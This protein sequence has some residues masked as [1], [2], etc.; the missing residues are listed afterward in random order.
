MKNIILASSS[1]RYGEEYLSYLLFSLQGHFK[2][3]S[4]VIFIPYACPGGISWDEY[5]QK[6]TAVFKKLDIKLIGLHTFAQPCEAIKKAQAI[7]TGGGNTF[8]L[9]DKLYKMGAMKVLREVITAGTPYLGTSA[10]SNI[11][12]VNIKNTNDMPIVFPPAFEALGLIPFNINPHYLD[13]IPHLKYNGETRE[14]RIIEYLHQNKVPVVGLR[15][16]S[17][18]SVKGNTVTLEGD[19]SAKIFESVDKIYEVEPQSVISFSSK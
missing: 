6:A 7:F 3:V 17:W 12:G 16:G 10:G 1:A 15:E 8:L 2:A 11:A 5:T 18:L 4:E 14:T 19:L 13:V 9:L